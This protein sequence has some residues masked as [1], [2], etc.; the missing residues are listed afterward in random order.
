[1]NRKD[2][3]MKH[4]MAGSRCDLALFEQLIG[5][6]ILQHFVPIY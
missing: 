1:M 4:C 3:M 2:L 5:S 6:E